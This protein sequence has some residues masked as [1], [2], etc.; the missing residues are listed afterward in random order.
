[1]D[2]RGRDRGGIEEVWR[3]DRRGRED[4][5]RTDRGGT[6]EGKRRGLTES[7]FL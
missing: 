4:G 5:Q 6:A 3:M 2:R 1:M 7:Q